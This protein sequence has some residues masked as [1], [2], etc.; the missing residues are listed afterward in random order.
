MDNQGRLFGPVRLA[1]TTI[2]QLLTGKFEEVPEWSDFGFFEKIVSHIPHFKGEFLE[3]DI[4]FFY[5]E[6]HV[7]TVTMV[8]LSREIYKNSCYSTSP[9]TVVKLSYKKRVESREWREVAPQNT[10]KSPCV[11]FPDLNGFSLEPSLCQ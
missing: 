6:A 7:A 10:Q 5:K 9:W 11:G 3:E 2:M 8:A 4:W 1:C